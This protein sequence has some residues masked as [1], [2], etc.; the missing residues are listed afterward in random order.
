MAP[1]DSGVPNEPTTDN[2]CRRTATET[3]LTQTALLLLALSDTL[4]QTLLQLL[5]LLAAAAFNQRRLCERGQL[6]K[7]ILK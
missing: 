4:N 1:F 2:I 6:D 5:I 3:A 7:R